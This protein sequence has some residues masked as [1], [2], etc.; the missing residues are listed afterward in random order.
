MPL[1]IDT[2]TLAEQLTKVLERVS[3]DREQFVIEQD[4]RPVAILAPAAEPLGATAEQVAAAL[5]DLRT[6][7]P[8]FADDL[9]ETRS[10][11]PIAASPERGS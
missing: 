7:D 10:G 11:Q 1:T 6:P 2:T 5:A 8:D 9:E 4:G 3:R